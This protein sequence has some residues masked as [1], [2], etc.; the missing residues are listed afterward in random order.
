MRENDNLDERSEHGYD[1]HDDC[2]NVMELTMSTIFK[3]IIIFI[4]VMILLILI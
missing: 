1:F 3:I 2:K 4:I